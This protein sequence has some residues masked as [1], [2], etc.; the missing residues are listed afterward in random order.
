MGGIGA[1]SGVGGQWGDGEKSLIPHSQLP[2]T[3]Y[4][5]PITNSQFPMPNSPLHFVCKSLH[6]GK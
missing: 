1:P 4:Q 2:I 6:S 3:N 5:F